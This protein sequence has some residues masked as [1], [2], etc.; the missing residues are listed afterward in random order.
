M[1]I[2]ALLIQ[3][4]TAEVGVI[5]KPI[6]RNIFKEIVSVL[7]N[8]PGYNKKRNTQNKSASNIN[9]SLKSASNININLKS[10]RPK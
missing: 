5:E 1:I 9:I 4:V 10:A 7:K 2:I 3:K 8:L 6:V